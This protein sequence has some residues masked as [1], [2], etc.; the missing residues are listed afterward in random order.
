MTATMQIG[1]LA[2]TMEAFGM[3]HASRSLPD[4]LELADR[5]DLT[6]REFLERVLL[7]ETEGRFAAKSSGSRSSTGSTRTATSCS[8]ARRGWGRR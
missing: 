3:K 8:R 1:Q 2:A 5:N 6:C 4:L 7:S